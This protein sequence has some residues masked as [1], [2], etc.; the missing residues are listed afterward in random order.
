[1]TAM[2]IADATAAAEARMVYED[3]IDDYFED[4][5]DIVVKVANLNAA[6][7]RSPRHTWS[8][9]SSYVRDMLDSPHNQLPREDLITQQAGHRAAYSPAERTRRLEA[10]AGTDHE[11]HPDR[12]YQL[13]W[14]DGC[15]WLRLAPIDTAA[16]PAPRPTLTQYVR[17]TVER[18]RQP[19]DRPILLSRLYATIADSYAANYGVRPSRRDIRDA[20]DLAPQC[21]RS[22]RAAGIHLVIWGTD[23]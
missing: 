3:F 14:R 11:S 13:F 8:S 12:E 5:P 1:M 17:A 21:S 7:V 22:R 15:R 10:L 16:A 6:F 20:L 18:A 23:R 4:D 2:T 19:K 9:D